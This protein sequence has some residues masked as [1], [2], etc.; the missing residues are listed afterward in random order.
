MQNQKRKNVFATAN[1]VCKIFDKKADKPENLK[2][3]K[4]LQM[5]T[6]NKEKSFCK[7]GRTVLTNIKIL[8]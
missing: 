6:A 8:T 3:K 7:N 1:R 4:V 2:I 5:Q